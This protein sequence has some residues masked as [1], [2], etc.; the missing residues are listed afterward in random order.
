M[1]EGT[2]ERHFEEYIE[3]LRRA[4]RLTPINSKLTHINLY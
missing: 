3:S 2:K 4:T 1:A